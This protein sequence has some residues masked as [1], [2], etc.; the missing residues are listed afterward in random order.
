MFD[1]TF[2]KNYKIRSLSE[3]V[4]ILFL[5]SENIK[6][7]EIISVRAIVSASIVIV[8]TFF[9]EFSLF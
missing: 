4:K 5:G 3:F 8:K 6:F 1:V 2:C 9:K 7:V